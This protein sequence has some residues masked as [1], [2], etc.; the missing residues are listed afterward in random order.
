MPQ[1]EVTMV[2]VGDVYVQR[3]EPDTAFAPVKPFLEKAD[4]GFCNLETVIADAKYL[5][6]GDISH[7][8]R[9]DESILPSYVKAGFN[10]FNIANNPVMY[11]GLGC[12]SRHLDLL[13]E[14]GVVYGG[15]GRNITA[16]R[17][18]AI[19]E[20]NGN[21]IAFVC[22]TSVGILSAG[23]T[24]EKPGL[25]R[26]AVKVAY[27]PRERALEVPGCAPYVRTF[28]DPKDQAALAEDIKTARS[29]ADVVI[30]SWHWGVSP[31]TGG[32]GDLVGY[33]VEMAH[34][35]LDSGAD[36]VVG[37][38]PH[39]LQPIE[40]YKGKPI[41]YS[42]GNYVHDMGSMGEAG[43]RFTSMLARATFRDGK[44]AGLSYVPA[45]LEGN[46]PPKFLKPADAKFIVDYMSE[47]SEPYGTKFQVGSDEVSVVLANA[48]PRNLFTEEG[49]VR[50]ESLAWRRASGIV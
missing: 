36:M 8:P 1:G 4:V 12:F 29:Q 44:V 31:A 38:H 26:F 23:A 40:V 46:G 34:F 43:R 27:E 37:H 49:P 13:D 50:A 42:L 20:K 21:R 15:G 33:Q 3:P 17:K 22:R 10:V 25:A 28:A 48:E 14:A 47:V 9:T 11:H 41:I 6:P 45:I 5:E 39:V 2:M 16:A 35:A 7:R 24:K 19:I 32:V 30:V 18:P